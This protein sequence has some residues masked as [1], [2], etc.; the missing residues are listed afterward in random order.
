ML[1]GQ[2]TEEK[3]IR[4][5][6]T[7]DFLGTKRAFTFRF[8]LANASTRNGFVPR[9][10]ASRKIAFLI[11]QVRQEGAESA[12]HPTVV[13][14]TTL[15]DPRSKELIEEILRLSTRFGVLSEYTAFLATEGTDLED[16]EAIR[17]TA[18][19]TLDRRAVHTRSGIGAVSQNG[20]IQFAK[21]QQ[22]LNGA[23]EYLDESNNRVSISS[24]QQ[25]SDRAFFR[26]GNRWIDAR[27]IED[28]VEL[29]PE[30]IVTFGSEAH[31]AMVSR[32]VREGRQGMLS[33]PGE[34]LVE[35][36]GERILVQNTVEE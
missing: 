6:L 9:L 5:R 31:R 28:G 35:L 17:S 7:G 16:W 29:E 32:F 22:V 24:V 15:A 20:N 4:F 26:R 10:W 19:A 1:L 30:S 2:Y 8:D 21:R 33:M 3:P 13:G 14:T 27:L 18:T 11:D 36:D 12:S 34:I 25:V 23:N